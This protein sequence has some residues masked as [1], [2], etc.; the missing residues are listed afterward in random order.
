MKDGLVPTAIGVAAGLAGALGLSR[1]IGSLLFGVRPTD[2]STLTGVIVT[3]SLIAVGACWLPA[4]RASQLD[5]NL[6]LRED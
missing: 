2:I 6:V 1:L 4:W 5:P 3:V